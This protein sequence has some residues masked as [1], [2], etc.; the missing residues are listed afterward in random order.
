MK[1]IVLTKEQQQTAVAAIKSY[2]LTEKDEEITDLAATL[3]LDFIIKDIGPLIYNQA[4]KDA[5]YFL[6][7]K[8]DDLYSLEKPLSGKR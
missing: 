6:T 8:L 1:G 7:E 5:H 4:L 2:F 3:L